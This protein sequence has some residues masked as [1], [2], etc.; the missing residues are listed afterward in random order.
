MTDEESMAQV[1]DA[2]RQLR[3]VAG[4]QD[5]TGGG[6]LASCNDDGAPPNRGYIEMSA[7]L[8]P[9]VSGHD[10]A[11][12]VKKAMLA[13]G[14]SDKLPTQHNYGGTIN[15]NGVAINIEYYQGESRLAFKLYGECRNMTNHH[16]DSKNVGTHL[17]KELNSDG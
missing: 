13:A 5:V 16:G 6:Y 8:P 15:R 2:G 14:W 7:Q 10:Y 11:E 4:L 9:G 17:D 12:Q 3:K 1:L